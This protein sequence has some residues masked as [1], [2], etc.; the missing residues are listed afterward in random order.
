MNIY[1]YICTHIFNIYEFS[2]VPQHFSGT[3]SGGLSN[4]DYDCST[5][6]PML[7]SPY[8]GKLTM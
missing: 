3:F 7:G 8:S 5:L 2:R 4:K 1:I 6:W